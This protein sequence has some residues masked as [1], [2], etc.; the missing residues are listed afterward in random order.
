[1]HKL[2]FYIISGV[3]AFIVRWVYY[4]IDAARE[5]KGLPSKHREYMDNGDNPMNFVNFYTP[6][7]VDENFDGEESSAAPH[8]PTEQINEAELRAKYN[9]GDRSAEMDDI[10]PIGVMPPKTDD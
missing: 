7:G 4:F 8:M 6:D 1:M 5:K 9:F 10:A 3:I 2:Y